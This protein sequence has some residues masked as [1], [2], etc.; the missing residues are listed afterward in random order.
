MGKD[1]IR[2]L[3]YKDGR[4]IWRPTKTMRR[5]GFRTI[6]L[7]PG[8]IIDGERVPSPEDAAR[9]TALNQDWDRHRRG[10]PPVSLRAKYP[11]GS[12]GVA[13]ERALL[14]REAERKAKGIVWTTE[15]HSR[16]DWPRAWRWIEPLFGDSDPKTVEPEQLI[17]DPRN[18]N[19]LGLRPLVAFK[20]SE[21]EAYRV[22]KVWRALWKR[23]AGFGYCDLARDPSFQFSN[24][25]PQPRQA[26][27]S[28]GE[29]VRLVKAA[30]RTGYHGLAALLAVAWDSQ[31][32][33][34]DARRL[35][36]AQRRRDVVGTFFV[37]GRAKTG[38]SALAT[39]SRRAERV[40]HA[41]LAKVA[42][43]PVGVAAIFRNR[44][45]TP[46]SKDTLGDDFRAVRTMVFSMAET[47]QLADFRR[48]GSVEALAGDVQPEKLSSKM[49]NSLSESNRLHK[50]YAP[51]QL[52]AVRDADAARM[53][54]RTS[55]RG[56]SG[57]KEQISTESV[58]APAQKCPAGTKR[59]D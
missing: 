1:K 25:A 14:L 17:G 58:R 48:S 40:L 16:D 54:G 55:L 50:T 23:A 35:Q 24:S 26:V 13:Y 37:V 6:K 45:G 34:V 2:Y 52:A 20:V 21:S 3:L 11:P 4:W 42:A 31:L 12:L 8:L 32:S 5:A 33:P 19:V 29:A 47:R 15:Q 57:A 43:E 46:Y 59:G 18:P 39:L 53:R 51:V 28:E 44:S 9:A 36:A 7:G 38:R 22:I 10:L 41:Y 27:W 56:Q 49:A 30:W